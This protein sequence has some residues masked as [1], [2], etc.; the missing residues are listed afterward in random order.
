ME[1]QNWA[2][3]LYI[4]FHKLNLKQLGPVVRITKATS[5]PLQNLI[6][7][8]KE[9]INNLLEHSKP[10]GSSIIKMESPWHAWVFLYFWQQKAINVSSIEHP[11]DIPSPVFRGQANSSYG[12]IP[13]FHRTDTNQKLEKKKLEYFTLLMKT[14]EI[15]NSIGILLSEF[16]IKATA[17]HYQVSLTDFVDITADPA[18]AIHFACSSTSKKRPETS[19]V[20]MFDLQDFIHDGA[21]IVMPPPFA[22]RLYLQRGGFLHTNPYDFK[23]FQN[24]L[25]KIEFPHDPDF[26]SM[27]SSTPTNLLPTTPWF[28]KFNN[29]TIDLINK[30]TITHNT[31]RRILKNLCRQT[32][33]KISYPEFT[34]NTPGLHALEWV[35]SFAD[36]LYWFAMRT[37]QDK[38]SG[39][40]HE[41]IL[42]T[43]ALNI[44]KHNKEVINQLIHFYDLEDKTRLSD[45][46]KASLVVTHPIPPRR[47]AKKR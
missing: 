37:Y 12:V 24:W 44:A 14:K 28:E 41:V 6:D 39:E 34:S 45:F 33:E 4:D 31:P 23:K 46:W 26:K 13:S 22:N 5:K 18:V 30:Q 17:Q 32:L 29:E 35:S 2:K 9:N 42:P 11:I 40:E 1:S 7:N 15:Q 16:D 20:F 10:Q 36:H 21:A 3:D 25:I 47:S 8:H 27:R 43:I 19:A 38:K